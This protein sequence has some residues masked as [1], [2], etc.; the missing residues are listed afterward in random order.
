MIIDEIKKDNVQAI[1]DK[2]TPIVILIMGWAKTSTPGKNTAT[3]YKPPNTAA[4]RYRLRCSTSPARR[5]VA[6]SNM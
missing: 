6:S 4:I 5:A 2:N 1:K 3:A